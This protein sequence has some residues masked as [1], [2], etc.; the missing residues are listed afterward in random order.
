M[1][2]PLDPSTYPT[3]SPRVTVCF[4]YAYLSATRQ[5]GVSTVGESVLVVED[6]PADANLIQETFSD[7]CDLTVAEDG[8]TALLRLEAVADAGRIPALVVLDCRLPDQSGLDVLRWIRR[9][10]RFDETVVVVFTSSDSAV[11]RRRAT[12]FGADGFCTK[13]M[14]I[15]EFE[16][17]IERLER[18]VF[19]RSHG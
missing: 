14:D 19:G 17:S 13:P 7:R 15:D 5:L 16:N 9:D 2:R 8:K 18:S 3:V 11:D 6:H 12:E 10:S 4:A 1:C